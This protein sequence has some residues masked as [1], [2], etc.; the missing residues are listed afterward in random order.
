M[1]LFSEITFSELYPEVGDTG[2]VLGAFYRN[3]YDLIGPH[4]Q[5]LLPQLW[6]RVIQP[7]WIIELR[8][9]NAE[10]NVD[11]P[12]LE[13][14]DVEFYVDLPELERT[15]VKARLN[16]QYERARQDLEKR[17][18]EAQELEVGQASVLK[19]KHGR[20]GVLRVFKGE[21]A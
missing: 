13:R 21:E 20:E 14:L 18:L 4:G 6:N 15:E 1:C 19:V 17:R 7:G 9:H 16:R 10:F 5:R 2:A 8:F 12:E 11:L 3:E